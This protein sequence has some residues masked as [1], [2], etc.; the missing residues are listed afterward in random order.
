MTPIVA[1]SRTVLWKGIDAGLIDGFFVNG[2]AWLMRGLA[3]I[4]SWLQSGQVGAYAWAIV[5]GV[6]AML[7]AFTIR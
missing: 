6:L 7:G 5:I 1:V 3:R 2:S 4:G